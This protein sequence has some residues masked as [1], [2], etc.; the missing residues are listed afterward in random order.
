MWVFCLNFY[1]KLIKNFDLENDFGLTM[2][3]IFFINRKNLGKEFE[4]YCLSN[5]FI[6][7]LRKEVKLIGTMK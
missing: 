4:K 2:A 5:E 6:K 1:K 3:P 7:D